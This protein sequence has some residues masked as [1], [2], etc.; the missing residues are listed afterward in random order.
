MHG[1]MHMFTE[2]HAQEHTVPRE[3]ARVVAMEVE[4]GAVRFT[5]RGDLVKSKSMKHSEN[6][7]S[8]SECME[9]TGIEPATSWLQT[10]RSPS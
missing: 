5:D 6:A 8:S 1:Q 4:A 2:L 9:R 3:K 10:R 7:V